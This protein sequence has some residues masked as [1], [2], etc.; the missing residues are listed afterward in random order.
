[1]K[2]VQVGI[3]RCFGGREINK[4]KVE[5]IL[6]DTL[7]IVKK[8]FKRIWMLR[9][10]QNLGAS[11]KQLLDVYFKQVRSVLELA[12]PVWHSSLSKEDSQNIERV[13][14]SAFQV[15]LGPKYTSY[16]NACKYLNV[17]PLY[18]RR[19]HLCLKFGKKAFKKRKFTNGLK[20]TT[21]S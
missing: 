15:I 3:S 14:K 4:T 11:E 5:T 6:W 2:N 18:E 8:A 1:M 12:V 9:R 19:Q 13:Q 21:K 20:S 16:N 17:Q 7:Y 10:I